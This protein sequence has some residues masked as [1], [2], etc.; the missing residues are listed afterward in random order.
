D[1]KEEEVVIELIAAEGMGFAFIVPSGYEPGSR[2][3]RPLANRR[4][5][6]HS[7]LDTSRGLRI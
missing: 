7:S 1:R 4:A 6:V 5:E 3:P 2:T